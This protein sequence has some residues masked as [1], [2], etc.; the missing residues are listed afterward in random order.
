ML[1]EN[2]NLQN[3]FRELAGELK[4]LK[5]EREDIKNT[6]SH[7]LNDNKNRNTILEK[8]VQELNNALEL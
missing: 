8:K 4:K 7:D 2:A 3:T 6:L 5:S 1:E